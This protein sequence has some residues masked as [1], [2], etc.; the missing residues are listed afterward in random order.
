[1]VWSVIAY[2]LVNSY[3]IDDNL[4]RDR[5]I[6]VMLISVALPFISAFKNAMFLQDNAQP[7]LM[8]L[9]STFIDTE[10][11]RLLPALSLDFSQ[12]ENVCSVVAEQLGHHLT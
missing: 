12:I 8:Y 6:S 9:L 5:Y 10:S 3:F 1:M 4:N 2:V 7:G 11:F